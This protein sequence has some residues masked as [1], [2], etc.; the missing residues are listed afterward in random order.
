MANSQSAHKKRPNIIS[1]LSVLVRKRINARIELLFQTKGDIQGSQVFTVGV[2]Q[3]QVF[4][5]KT[6]AWGHKEAFIFT[7]HSFPRCQLVTMNLVSL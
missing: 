5:E 7:A 6:W 1:S 2:V 3:N 4:T